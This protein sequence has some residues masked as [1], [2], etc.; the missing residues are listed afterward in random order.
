MFTNALAPCSTASERTTPVPGGDPRFD[1]SGA[2][3]RATPRV[4]Q[5]CNAALSDRYWWVDGVVSCAR[6]VGEVRRAEARARR[7]SSLARAALHAAPVV[8]V[9]GAGYA[10]L[11]WATDAWFSWVTIGLGYLIGVAVRSAAGRFSTRQHQALA[12]ALTYVTVCLGNVAPVAQALRPEGAFAVLPVC[13]LMPL[14]ALANGF[15]GAVSI[16]IV[17]VGLREAWRRSAGA[18]PTV[19]GPHMLRCAGPD[20]FGLG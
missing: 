9:G 2:A 13:L 16:L 11:V 12:V 18:A 17:G 1:L 20:A 4:C 19:A 6:C 7:A 8:A 15:S 5:S 10:L 14:L 3:A